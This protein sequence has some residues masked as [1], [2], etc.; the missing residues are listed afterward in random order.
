MGAF[1]DLTWSPDS[2]WLAYT[3]DADNTYPQIWIYG[4]KTSTA[5]ALTSDR[6][7]S[8]SPVWSPDGKWIYF[9]SDRHLESAVPSPWGLREPEPYFDLP[10]VLYH[11][12]LVKEHRSPF[13]PL[14][15]LHPPPTKDKKKTEDE[16]NAVPSVAIDLAGI[17]NRVQAVPI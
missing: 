2:Q 3:R 12:P 14:D 4:L 6:V 15:E 1:G 5:T 10:V 9:L 7:S 16:T 8:S 11:V 13:A 17:Q